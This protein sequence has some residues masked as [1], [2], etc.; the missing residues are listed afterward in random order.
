MP[1]NLLIERQRHG[2]TQRRAA[3]LLGCDQTSFV[4]WESGK[5]RPQG[6]RA[7]K[8]VDL[9]DK[10]LDDL[11]APVEND[12]GAAQ[13]HPRDAFSITTVDEPARTADVV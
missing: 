8:L 11:L 12:E 7:A 1:T 9:F 10:P 2:W 6:V 5:V 4:G 3:R 13:I